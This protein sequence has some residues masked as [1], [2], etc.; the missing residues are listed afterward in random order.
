MA[1]YT[2][3]LNIQLPTFGDGTVISSATVKVFVMLHWT[4]ITEF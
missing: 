1:C 4:L 3:Q 2:L